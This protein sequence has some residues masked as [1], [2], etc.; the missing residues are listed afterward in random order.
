MTVQK[1]DAAEYLV[2]NEQPSTNMGRFHYPTPTSPI[3][4]NPA[5]GGTSATS[6]TKQTQSNQGQKYSC[7]AIAA[8]LCDEWG[9]VDDRSLRKR[10]TLVELDEG[11]SGESDVDSVSS[12]AFV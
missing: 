3:F 6:S 10:L 12:Y 2:D 5:Q 4:P 11:D 1:V 9:N 7:D 8:R